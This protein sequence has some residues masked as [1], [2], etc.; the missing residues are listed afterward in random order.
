MVGQKSKLKGKGASNEMNLE[1]KYE[2][3]ESLKNNS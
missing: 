2:C 3:L 1:K